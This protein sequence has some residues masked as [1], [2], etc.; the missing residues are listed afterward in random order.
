MADS[1]L[2]L[3]L[4]HWV[5]DGAMALFFLVVGLEIKRELTIGH[6]VDRRSAMLPIAA[7]LGGMAVPALLY[8]AVAGR[9][10]PR[11]WAVPMATDIALAVGVLA[12]A[13]PRVP[14]S[15]RAFLLGLAIVD[16]I[17]AIVVIAVAYSS[18]VSPGWLVCAALLVAAAGAARRARIRLHAPFVVIGIALWF[19]LH[20]SGVHATL[21]GVAMGLL[22]PIGSTRPATSVVERLERAFHPWTSYAILPIFAVASAGTEISSASIEGALRSWVA[23]G[24]VVGLVAGKPIGVF[25]AAR[26]ATRPGL[27]RRPDGTSTPHIVG[28]GHA[29]GVGF[30]VALFI[31]E[32]AFDDVSRQQSVKLAILAASAVSAALSL[33]VL[34]RATAQPT[35]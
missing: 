19:A 14:P 20:Q 16:D 30:T 35:A 24:V 18:G 33:A 17:G 11:G 29:A 3:D 32:L 4:R 6:L 23:W 8:L 1:A 10:D 12:I 15:G 13:G 26:L 7:A 28:I 27:A 5:T 22:A 25:A 9:T 31:A 34:R 2:R 21:A